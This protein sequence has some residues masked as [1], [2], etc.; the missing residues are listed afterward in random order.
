L[1]S[2]PGENNRALFI[3][4]SLIFGNSSAL[5]SCRIRQIL[6]PAFSML[7]RAFSAH[8]SADFKNF[9]QQC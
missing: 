5:R 6:T 8:K 7:K 4:C 1:L 3:A 2:F 9:I